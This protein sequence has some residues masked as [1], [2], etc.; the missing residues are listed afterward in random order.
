MR[1]DRISERLTFP[2]CF[3]DKVDN[4]QDVVIR[5]PGLVANVYM[6]TQGFL[7]PHDRSIVEEIRQIARVH[8]RRH[9]DKLQVLI[10]SQLLQKQEN[11]LG[12]ARRE[13]FSWGR[14]F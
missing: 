9:N 13:S 7:Q 1:N 4:F 5:E 8:C 14:N 10:L 12:R 11:V 2:C 3:Q 6:M